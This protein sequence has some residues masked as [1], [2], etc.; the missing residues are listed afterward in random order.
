MPKKKK[1]ANGEGTIY[2]VKSGKHKGKWIAQITIGKYPNGRPKRKSFYG[3]SR[4]EVKRRMKDYLDER[5]LGVDQEAAAGLTFGEWLADWLEL[6]K[7]PTVRQSTIENYLM[8]TRLHIYPALGQ[9]YLTDLDTNHIQALYNKLHKA[10]KAPATI[11]K[12]HQIVHSCLEKAVEKRL[13]MWNPSKATERPSVTA[14]EAVAMSEEDM[15]KFL[16]VVEKESHKWKAAFLT[17]LGTGLRIGELL[18]LEWDDIDFEKDRIYVRRTLSRTK[19]KGLII[20]NPKTE[21]SKSSVPMPEV[22]KDALEKHK[23]AQKVIIMENRKTYQN[24]ALVFG[25]DKGT[26]MIP[27]NFQRKYYRL[28]DKA[29]VDKKVNLHGLRHTFATRLLEQGEELR[30]IQELLRHSDIKTTANIYLKGFTINM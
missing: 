3:K 8:Y 16:A 2:Q 10:G 17:L 19:E 24:T 20:E 11:H 9:I 23:K 4:S 6:Y 25:T 5:N 26:Y 18:A 21:K 30:V 1:N 12:I 13:L 28:R 22:V 14:Q 27:R 7:K 15:D 29:G